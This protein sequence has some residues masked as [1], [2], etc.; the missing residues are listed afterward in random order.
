MFVDVPRGLESLARSGSNPITPDEVRRAACAGWRRRCSAGACPNRN[1]GSAE[2]EARRGR[3]LETTIVRG[4][5]LQERPEADLVPRLRRLRRR[6]GHLPRAR[7]DR[8]AA[9]RDRVRLGHRLLEPHP[10]LHDRV[11]LQHACTGARCRSRRASSWRARSCSCSSPAATATASRSA[12]ATCAHAIRRNVDLTYIVMDNQIYGLTKGQLSPTSPRGLKTVTSAYGSLE[13]P[14]NPLLYVLG[15]GGRFVAQ[16]TP[17]DMA[18]L[19]TLI[20]EGIRFPG[21]AFI[22]VQSPCVTYGQPDAQLKAHKAAMKSLDVARPRPGGPARGAGSRRATTARSS[23]P[24]SSTATRLRSRPTRR[25]R[26]SGCAR[27]RGRRPRGRASSRCSSRTDSPLSYTRRVSVRGVP[28]SAGHVFN[29][30]R[31]SPPVN[32][33]RYH[34]YRTVLSAPRRHECNLCGWRGRH[35]LTYPSPAHPVSAVRIADP[36][37]PDR[38]G[39]RARAGLDRGARD[40]RRDGAA[41]RCRVLP[42]LAVRAESATLRDG[43]PVARR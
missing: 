39:A 30:L 38:R 18:G 29:R 4:D 26:P 34:F 28:P 6:A 43:G 42:G 41:F 23:T 10:R 24:A 15:Y 27:W 40:R 11:R 16:G 33:L 3:S 19:A 37:P 31:H 22:N 35:F 12:A 13:D 20:E 7:R 8:A 9:A 5:G 36:S 17:A 2:R 14:V 25:R 21:F 32:Q 1:R